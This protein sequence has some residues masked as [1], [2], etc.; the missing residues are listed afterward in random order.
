MASITPE[1]IWRILETVKDPE[2]PVVSV[3]ELG[4]IRSVG[5][6]EGKVVVSFTPTFAGCPALLVMREEIDQR[7]RQAGAQEVEVKLI[8]SP[9]WSSD[10]ITSTARRKL[11]EFGLAPPPRHAGLV[12]Q[13]LD[14][15]AV[16]PYCGS[17]ETALKNSFGPTLC[18]AI[19]FC[20]NC[21]QP[22]EQFKPV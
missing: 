22:F 20:N 10:W 15:A 14:E 6:Q 9:A 2:I 5:V 12:E 1:E 3:V 21:R 7:L 16:C 11:R 17:L 19:Y 18:R 4:L 13:V 8:Y